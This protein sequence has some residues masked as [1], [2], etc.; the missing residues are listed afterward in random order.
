MQQL[1]KEKVCRRDESH[2]G[3]QALLSKND[4]ETRRN[5]G[6]ASRSLK[7]FDVAPLFFI[8]HETIQDHG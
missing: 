5:Q 2:F 8:K 3:L 1:P 6:R 7:A 4:R